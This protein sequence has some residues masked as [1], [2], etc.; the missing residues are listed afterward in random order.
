MSLKDYLRDQKLAPLNQTN[1]DKAALQLTTHLVIQQ[2]YASPV[3]LNMIVASLM[4]Q[5]QATKEKFSTIFSATK[6]IYNYCLRRGGVKMIMRQQPNALQVLGT[7]QK[8]GFDCT[9]VKNAARKSRVR[10]YDINMD[11]KRE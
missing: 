1:L 5:S 2:E 6:R 4:L 9:E 8:L 10:E 11:A 3:V 7:I